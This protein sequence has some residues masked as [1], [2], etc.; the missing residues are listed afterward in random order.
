VGLTGRTLGSLGLGNIGQ[1][2]FRIAAPLGMRHLAADP[3]V[4]SETAAAVGV[5]LVSMDRLLREAD[6]LCIN[7]PLLPETRGIINAAALAKMK[8]TA[9]LVNT[10][11]GEIVQTEDLT[12]AL[13]E[14]LLA[15]AGL[16][17]TDPE[18]LPPEHPLCGMENVILAPHAL[19]WTDEIALGNGR[20]ACESLLA[21]ARGEAPV[22]RNL[23][24][25]DVLQQPGFIAKLERWR[26]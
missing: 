24:N 21:C 23:V 11:R 9:Y 10:A 19:A 7:T 5:E 6:F 15:G 18:P 13:Q 14:G 8:P 20:L 25:R 22:P 16:D 26:T 2:L 17:V 3:F 1:E 4:S 12:R